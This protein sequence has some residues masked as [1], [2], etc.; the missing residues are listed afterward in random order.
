MP[1]PRSNAARPVRTAV[2]PPE[3]RRASK[4]IGA[5]AP[6]WSV[7]LRPIGGASD[8]SGDSDNGCLR[9]RQGRKFAQ[10]HGFDGRAGCG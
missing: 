3:L 6:E 5:L 4:S 10:R 7:V 1:H 2:L 8:E 9:V